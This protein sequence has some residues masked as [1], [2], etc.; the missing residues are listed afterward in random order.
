MLLVFGI[1][2]DTF[3]QYDIEKQELRDPGKTC[4]NNTIV[5]INSSLH[6]NKTNPSISCG[7][8]DIESEMTKFAAYYAGI[9]CAVLVLGYF[10]SDY[11][12]LLAKTIAYLMPLCFEVKEST[13]KSTSTN[14]GIAK[15]QY[16]LDVEPESN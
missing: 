1:M 13:E 15:H 8:L 3:V 11:T 14:V 16:K 6:Q 4:V 2:T 12:E 9:G 7:L 5:W 10:Q